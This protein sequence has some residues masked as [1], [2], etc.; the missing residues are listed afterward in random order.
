MNIRL[1]RF[2]GSA[3][4]AMLLCLFVVAAAAQQSDKKAL[5][6]RGKV[7]QVNTATKRLT[8]H[9]EPVEGWMGEM[10]MGFAVDND[11]VFDRVKAG[12]QVTAKVYEGD[13]TLHD[14]QVVPAG[15]AAAAPGASTPRRSAT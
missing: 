7:Q 15:T 5:T 2:V 13:L 12:D 9:S 10:T 1:W 11:A 14:V 3:A 4:P 6:F 8:I